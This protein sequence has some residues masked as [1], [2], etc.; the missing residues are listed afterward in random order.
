MQPTVSPIVQID[1]LT[2]REETFSHVVDLYPFDTEEKA[3]E[4][5]NDCEASLSNF[6]ITESIFRVR[7]VAQSHEIG[8]ATDSLCMLRAYESPVQMS[9]SK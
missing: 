4:K 9:P 2:T 5:R 3:I 7:E 8:M 1:T 6:L